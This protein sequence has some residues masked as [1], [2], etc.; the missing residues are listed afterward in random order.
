MAIGTLKKVNTKNETGGGLVQSVGSGGALIQVVNDAKLTAATAT[1]LLAP[2]GFA[3]AGVSWVNRG[4][5][6]TRVRIYARMAITGVVTTSPI[7][8][9]L[10]A[11]PVD[12]SSA[13]TT[14]PE[15]N[16]GAIPNDG[17]WIH[18]RL[19]S[20]LTLTLV[21][22]GTGLRQDSTYAYSDPTDIIDLEDGFY[23]TV[24]CETAANVTGAVSIFALCIA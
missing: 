4:S 11:Y 18:A 17:T 10:S 20:A 5:G 7:I 19:A 1:E 9:V 21:S 12:P 8:R 14:F 3:G 24:L 23:F 2:F 6:V 15:S 16:N 22:S 13:N